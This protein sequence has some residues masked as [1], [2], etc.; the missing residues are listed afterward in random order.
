MTEYNKHSNFDGLCD[1]FI[2][3]GKSNYVE[4]KIVMYIMGNIDPKG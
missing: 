4:G 1:L 2:L 3:W